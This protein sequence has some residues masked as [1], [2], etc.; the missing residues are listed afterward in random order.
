MTR[1]FTVIIYIED[2]AEILNAYVKIGLYYY[3]V[4]FLYTYIYN[5]Y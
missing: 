4:Y 3:N 1:Y 2:F 5:I